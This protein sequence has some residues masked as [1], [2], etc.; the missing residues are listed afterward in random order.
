MFHINSIEKDCVGSK[1]RNTR[2]KILI[3]KDL[4]RLILVSKCAVCGKEKSRVIKNQEGSRLELHKVF[5]LF[6]STDLFLTYFDII[7]LKR[8]KIVNKFL[9]PRDKFMIELHLRL[10]GFTYGACGLYT[11]HC[12][13]IQNFRKTDDLNYIY[14]YQLDK[15]CFAHDATYSYTKDLAKKTLS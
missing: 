2:S 14:K 6:C 15:A 7:R 9:L 5:S 10:T 8:N 4:N 11:K 1:K 13:R 12:G 3:I